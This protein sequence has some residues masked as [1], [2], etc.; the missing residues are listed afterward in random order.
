MPELE[1]VTAVY[2]CAA[3][4]GEYLLVTRTVPA[5]LGVF[6]PP[7]VTGEAYQVLGQDVDGSYTNGKVRVIAG[8]ADVTLRIVGGR[9]ATCR[10]D[11]RASIWEHAKLNGADFRAVGN[12]PG[13]VL[14]IREQTRLEFHYDYGTSHLVVPIVETT[15]SERQTRFTGRLGEAELVVTLV[16]EP[17]S[18]TMSDEVFPTRVDIGLG[19]RVFN[20]CGRPLH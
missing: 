6:L 2:H 16:G 9:T 4:R 5:G 11:R 13:W 3:S 7:D 17:C 12:E 1:A 10:Y 19:D 15:T 18:D 20:G 8:E 14:E